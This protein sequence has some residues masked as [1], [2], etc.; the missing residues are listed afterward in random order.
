M[1]KSRKPPKWQKGRREFELTLPAPMPE[2][3][4]DEK[5]RLG[6][7]WEVQTTK[8]MTDRDWTKWEMQRARDR[9]ECMP[10]ST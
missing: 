3:G 9:L 4:K 5:V 1:A 7:R 10:G 2:S 8:P 6:F